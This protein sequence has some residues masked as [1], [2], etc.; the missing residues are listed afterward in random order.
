MSICMSFVGGMSNVYSEYQELESASAKRVPSA[1]IQ[2][3]FLVVSLTSA[4]PQNPV[5]PSTRGLSSGSA[6]LPIRLCATGR[7]RSSANSWSSD[8]A[9]A[10]T[11]PPP[12]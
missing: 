5:I 11:M 12:T 3:A 10:A 2:S 4:V 1:S 7:D 6:P 9:S 8:A